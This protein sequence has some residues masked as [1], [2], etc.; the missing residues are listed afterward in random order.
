MPNF[1]NSS[2][3]SAIDVCRGIGILLVIYGH[4]LGDN[5]IRYLIYSFHMPLFFFLSGI[6]FHS[7]VGSSFF[8]LV[9]KYAYKMLLPYVGFA[10]ITY[11]FWM[12]IQHRLFSFNEIMY[13]LWGIMYGNGNDGFLLFNIALWFLP[14]LFITKVLFTLLTKFSTKKFFIIPAL[15]SIS[16]IDY[17]ISIWFS[18]EKLPFGFETALS[19]VVFFGAGYLWQ[20]SKKKKMVI[21]KYPLP[22]VFISLLVTIIFATINFQ[23]YAHQIDMRMNHLN[24]YFLFYLCAFSGILSC[25]LISIMIK[26]NR[27]LEY[28]GRNSMILFVWHSIVFSYFIDIASAP[29]ISQILATIRFFLPTIYTAFAIAIILTGKMLL[30]KMKVAKYVKYVRVS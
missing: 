16:L 6:F 25:V 17:A 27:V 11:L 22:F 10:L 12:P 14:C 7:S 18:S 9:K 28:L 4:V 24:N 8:F 1:K 21:L 13:Q 26:S 23:M 19:A 30:Q 15:F 29:F 20:Q 3:I 5:G 2:R